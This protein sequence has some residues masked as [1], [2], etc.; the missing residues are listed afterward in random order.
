MPFGE[1]GSARKGSEE[2]ALEEETMSN[3]M[4]VAARNGMSGGCGTEDP[5]A[6]AGISG[7]CGT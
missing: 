3:L 5:K 4:N 6:F 1:L 7:D 2:H